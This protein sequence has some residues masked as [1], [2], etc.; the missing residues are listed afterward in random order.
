MLVH[1]RARTRK[2]IARG[3]A[4]PPNITLSP[5][6]ACCRGGR[7]CSRVFSRQ[8]MYAHGGL[9]LSEEVEC[10]LEAKCTQWGTAWAG[11]I[12]SRTGSFMPPRSTHGYL[13]K[14]DD[15][16]QWLRHADIKP[17]LRHKRAN[18][19]GPDYLGFKVFM[20]LFYWK[21]TIFVR[22]FT[23][24]T[25]SAALAALWTF[26]N[27]RGY[28]LGISDICPPDFYIPMFAVT[29]LMLAVRLVLAVMSFM[30]GNEMIRII[31]KGVTD[32]MMLCVTCPNGTQGDARRQR[33]V[34]Q[35]QFAHGVHPSGSARVEASP[36]IQGR[37]PSRRGG[38]ITK[39]WSYFTSLLFSLPRIRTALHRS[40]RC[41]PTKSSTT[42]LTLSRKIA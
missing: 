9:F 7:T 27:R 42:T 31:T 17:K 37:L 28:L 38:A 24:A 41:S 15:E 2:T 8:N 18:M 22:A 33:A 26:I 5:H 10:T 35:T 30:R 6:E 3:Q 12:I 16:I 34:P 21:N 25:I 40:T 1:A 13:D 14:H 39:Q 19:A 4:P 36:Q 32:A 29:L 11:L 23:P 20:D